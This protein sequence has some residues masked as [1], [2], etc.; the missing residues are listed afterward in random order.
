M[1]LASERGDVGLRHRE[2]RPDF[3]GQ[4][5]FQPLSPSARACRPVPALPCC[6]YQ[7]RNSSV[8]RRPAG[9]CPVRRRYRH[10]RGCDRPSPVSALG[11]KKFHKPVVARFF[12]GGFQQFQL[13]RRI[14]P[15]VGAAFAQTVEFFR[16]R[17]DVLADMLDHG[18]Q[19]RL[20]PSRTLPDC[21]F[22]V[23]V[24][25]IVCLPWRI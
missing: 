1:F 6:Q 9:S 25:D 22:R 3:A 8:F 14:G 19:K 5:G 16:D 2:G 13:P 7:A 21:S 24:S 12:L 4:Q 17:I 18:V 11:R 10:S 20:A 23:G 15:A